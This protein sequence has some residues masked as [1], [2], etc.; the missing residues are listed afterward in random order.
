MGSK[1]Q[2]NH[3]RAARLGCNVE[4]RGTVAVGLVDV[5]P[6]SKVKLHKGNIPVE[7][8]LPERRA[9]RPVYRGVGMG[10]W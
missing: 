9:A 2:L 6:H 10:V 5:R 4:R 8:A 1:E 7:S 3:L